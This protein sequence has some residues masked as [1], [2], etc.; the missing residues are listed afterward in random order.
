MPFI[1]TNLSDL[2]ELDSDSQAHLL[3]VLD[4]VHVLIEQHNG[5]IGFDQYMSH[6]LY[7]P[8]LGYYSSG[9]T[10]FGASGDYVTAP[11]ISS[12]FSKTLANWLSPQ[13]AGNK[14]LLELGAGDGTMAADI[15]L[16]LDRLA[17][18]PDRYLILE[19]SADLRSRQQQ[20][21]RDRAGHLYERVQWLDT[22]DPN[23]GFSGVIIGNEVLDAMPVKRLTYQ[24]GELLEQGVGWQ[25][26]VGP[27]WQTRPP[28][29]QLQQRIEQHVKGRDEWPDG[30]STEIN[31]A[32]EGWFRTLADFLREGTILL[33]DYGFGASEYYHPQRTD[34]T[35]RCYHRHHAVDDPFFLPG[36]T[37]ITAWVDFTAVADAAD[38]A[39]LAV[40]G[41]TTQASFLMD[42]GLPA[43]METM[44]SDQ[45]EAQLEQAEAV[46][47]LLMPGEMGD[48]VKVIALDR[49]QTLQHQGFSR[50]MRYQL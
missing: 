6:V 44:A 36:L 14:D 1:K 4:S 22:L 24:S 40:S 15:L 13:L 23:T 48:S 20:T 31:L 3:K 42:A 37:D 12:L 27:G 28:G 21:L 33:L 19:L 25:H 10:K 32:L 45:L 39:G 8:G 11:M 30:Y 16:E 34:G 41:Y 29:V 18:P 17:S 43:L 7:A 5:F 50:D 35:L 26:N 9:T 49:N 47:Q 38:K 46:K 2:P